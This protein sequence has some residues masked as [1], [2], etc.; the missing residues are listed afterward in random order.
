MKNERVREGAR[1]EKV[2]EM[3]SHMVELGAVKGIGMD[4]YKD[5]CK[6]EHKDALVVL[7]GR[8]AGV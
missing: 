5:S 1:R 3:T 8:R 7:W 4:G 2:K 6:L